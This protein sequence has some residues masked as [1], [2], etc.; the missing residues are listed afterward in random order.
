MR[1]D[2]LQKKAE[3]APEAEPE[4]DENRRYPRYPIEAQVVFITPEYTEI[5]GT[6]ENASAAGVSIAAPAS[7]RIG[8]RLIVYSELLGRLECRM[9]RRH[10]R[11][12]AAEIEA[13]PLK[14]ER[15]AR[16][17]KW[18]ASQI[19][20][21][22]SFKRAHERIT[23]RAIKSVLRLRDGGT[24]DCLIKDFSR[25]GAAVVCERRPPVGTLVTIGSQRSRVVRHT[26]AGF[27]VEYLRLIPLE[28]FDENFVL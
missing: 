5:E 14:R 16:L 24:Y 9:V 15:L 10:E 13:T 22:R 20:A 23:P 17:L 2:N 18:A 4:F 25:A 12:F 27:A 19:S 1:S 11:G 28:A 3:F 21:G 8:Q 26:A 6:I 7:P